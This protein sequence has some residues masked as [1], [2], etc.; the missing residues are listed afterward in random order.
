MIYKINIDELKKG[1]SVAYD[2]KAK[3]ISPEVLNI[4]EKNIDC[5]LY[6]SDAADD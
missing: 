5:L 4:T 6:T 2:D 1:E 3:R